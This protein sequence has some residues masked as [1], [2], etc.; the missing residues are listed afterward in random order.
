M[1]LE[2]SAINLERVVAAKKHHNATCSLGPAVEVLIR[3]EDIE[4]LGWEDGD[5]IAGLRVTASTD[6]PLG[7][8]KV[9]CAG[10]GAG[11]AIEVETGELVEIA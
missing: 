1:D 11:E 6:R 10:E 7:G 9:I 8:F 5:T 4:R 2:A 3:P